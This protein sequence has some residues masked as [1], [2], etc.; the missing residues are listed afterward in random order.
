M[1]VFLLIGV[2]VFIVSILLC[3]FI[4]KFLKRSLS[5]TQYEFTAKFYYLVAGIIV[6]MIGIVIGK[7]LISKFI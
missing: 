2:C 3:N 1:I 7:I 6:L 5:K 4:L